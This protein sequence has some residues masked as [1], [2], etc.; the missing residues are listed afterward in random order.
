VYDPDLRS[1]GSL[2]GRGHGEITLS[3]WFWPYQI[4]S[5]DVV[6]S[7]QVGVLLWKKKICASVNSYFQ[8]KKVLIYA[9]AHQNLGA[10]VVST[11]PLTI[12]HIMKVRRDKELYVY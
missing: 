5:I 12:M 10:R 8:D 7:K 2:C 4:L 9:K 11:Q 1:P 6:L 3:L